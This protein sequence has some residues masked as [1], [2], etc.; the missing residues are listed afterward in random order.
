[1]R[2][3]GPW[4]HNWVVR[5]EKKR[6]RT[7]HYSWSQQQVKFMLRSSNTLP[8]SGDSFLE[9]RNGSFAS[10]H[11]PWLSTATC[12]PPTPP[13]KTKR[14][15]CL[16]NTIACSPGQL[17][18]PKEWP[19]YYQHSL[20]KFNLAKLTFENGLSLICIRLATGQCLSVCSRLAELL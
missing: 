2:G 4:S 11:C 6:R 12:N 16:P 1:M 5:R 18:S 8:A 19:N 9:L 20:R 13:P 10:S 17:R 14:N 7:F 15:S 3:Q